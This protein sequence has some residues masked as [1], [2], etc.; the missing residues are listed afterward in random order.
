MNLDEILQQA[1]DLA[2]TNDRK[3]FLDSVTLVQSILLP[4]STRDETKTCPLFD[5]YIL[6]NKQH[7]FITD[8]EL[9]TLI[10]ANIAKY[11]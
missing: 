8:P 11:K 2:Q 10:H 1:I 5:K 9:D 3:D 4:I 6:S 7:F